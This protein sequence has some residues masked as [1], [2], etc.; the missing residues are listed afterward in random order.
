MDAVYQLQ[1]DSTRQGVAP[2]QRATL[3]FPGSA[4]PMVV[5][6]SSDESLISR[7]LDWN[8]KGEINGSGVLLGAFQQTNDQS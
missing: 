8:L 4:I 7:N 3:T 6:V 1:E 5:V 2:W